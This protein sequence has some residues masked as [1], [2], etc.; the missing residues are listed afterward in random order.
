VGGAI[1]TEPRSRRIPPVTELYRAS[2][3]PLHDGVAKGEE[4]QQQQTQKQK[5]VDLAVEEVELFHTPDEKPYASI[6]LEGGWRENWPVR[7]RRFRQFLTGRYYKK[8]GMPP[9]STALKDA[10]A[11]LEAMAHFDGEECYV[12]LRIAEHGGRL[13]LDLG[14]ENREAI[15]IR[16]DGWSE[17]A[18]P[19]VK[20]VRSPTAAPLPYPVR[21]GTIEELRPFLNLRKADGPDGSDDDFRLVVGWLLNCLNPSGPYMICD[22]EGEQGSAKTTTARL[23]R[24]LVDPA[25][26]P[27]RSPPREVRD[28]AIAA[29]G[30]WMIALDNLSGLK[31]FLSDAL[32]RLATGGGSAY[33]TLYSDD[34]ETLFSAKRPV[35]LN[36]I[37]SIATR[38]DL[39]ERSVIL[40]LPAIPPEKRKTEREF[41]RDFEE[42]RPRLLGALLDAA[43]A[44]LRNLDRVVLDE[45]PRMAD[46]TRWVSAAES[47]LGWPEGSFANAFLTN[48]DRMVEAALETNLVAVAVKSFMKDYREG[49][50]WVGR[51][52]K[53]LEELRSMVSEEDQRSNSWPK[54]ANALGYWLRR[55]APQLR[56]VGIEFEGEGRESGSDRSRF[57]TL[58]KLTMGGDRPKRPDRPMTDDEDDPDDRF[59]SLAFG[60]EEGWEVVG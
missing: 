14:N 3:E 43:S 44:A 46:A 57:W 47:V 25:V 32:C 13:Y 45:S 52:T 38:V 22:L 54:S 33:R 18:D 17:V 24:S 55:L 23:L 58:R 28:L 59:P 10:I 8:M 51:P 16:P 34:E 27:M 42:V 50:E 30:N 41:W 19:P 48:Q 9:D 20:F 12:Y 39:Q 35:L 49:E 6:R 21:S 56:T 29:A 4:E 1:P 7:G 37:D 31:P 2:E 53:L 5:L 11:T 36:G 26:E 40:N 60:A 15:E